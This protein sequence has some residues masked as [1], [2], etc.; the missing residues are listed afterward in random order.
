MN[1]AKSQTQEHKPVAQPERP[2]PVVVP[3]L[4]PLAPTVE[5]ARAHHSQ[6]GA[7]PP[8]SPPSSP[9]PNPNEILALQR[10]VGNRVVQRTIERLNSSPGTPLPG[11]V[12]DASV[13]RLVDDRKSSPRENLGIVQRDGGGAGPGKGLKFKTPEKEWSV[14]RPLPGVPLKLGDIKLDMR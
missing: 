4:E 10:T 12:I 2:P 8:P 14:N 1:R 6:L 3:E 13:Q 11:F 5:W 9:P 7:P